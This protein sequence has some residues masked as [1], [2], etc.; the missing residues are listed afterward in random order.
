MEVLVT[1]ECQIFPKY[2]LWHPNQSCVH[3]SSRMS[4][5]IDKIEHV[6]QLAGLAKANMKTAPGYE[7]PLDILA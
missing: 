3:V 2:L 5:K 6:N 4:G 7:A 1:F